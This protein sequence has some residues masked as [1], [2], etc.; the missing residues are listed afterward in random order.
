MK[1]INRSFLSTFLVFSLGLILIGADRTDNTEG[2]YFG[3]GIHNGWADQTSIVIWTRLTKYPDMNTGGKQFLI[4]LPDEED[5]L[6]HSAD[7]ESIYKAQIPDGFVLDQME[8]ACPGM[9]GEV[10]LTYWLLKKREVRNVVDWAPVD[11]SKNFTKQWYL[12]DIRPDMEYVVEIQARK[13]ERSPVSAKITGRFR[14]PPEPGITNDVEFVVV[15]GTDYPR[16]DTVN[17]HKIYKAMHRMAPDFFVHTGD[18][19]Y[20]DKPGPFAMT[21]ELMRFKWD[22]MFALPL[23]RNFWNQ[24]TSYFMRDDHDVTKNDSYPGKDYGTV[25]FERGLEIFEEQF[26]SLS[27]EKFYKTIRWGRDLQIWIMEGRKYRSKNNMPDGPGKTIWGEEQ[28]EWLFKTIKESDATFK[29]L[30]TATPILG[31]DH[32]KKN[33]NHANE[34]FAYEGNEIREFLNQFDNLYIVTG[35]RHWQYVSHKSGTNL[36]EF[37]TGPS[38]YKHSY[39][40]HHLDFLPEHRFLRSERGGGFLKGSISYKGYKTDQESI[41][42]EDGFDPNQVYLTFTHH[43]VNGKILHKEVFT[44]DLNE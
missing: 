12:K 35:D 25:S 38:T 22:R 30:I 31:P 18:I 16:R 6:D 39:G 32:K 20:Y 36:W 41:S 26:P 24:T 42:W 13:N 15:T 3:N 19:E 1:F 5:E 29:V 37:A 8:G 2:P 4:P 34:G 14:T 28:K 40:W 23:Q 17:G 43:D 9:P 10:K 33:D 11:N 44:R 7:P 27:N 21:E